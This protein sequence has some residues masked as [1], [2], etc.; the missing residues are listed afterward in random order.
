[1]IIWEVKES[2]KLKK[3]NKK[4]KKKMKKFSDFFLILK[5]KNWN[6]LS[7]KIAV[8]DDLFKKFEQNN[9]IFFDFFFE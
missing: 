9:K 5:I 4:K 7:H 1:M 3:L 2:T 6:E 8:E